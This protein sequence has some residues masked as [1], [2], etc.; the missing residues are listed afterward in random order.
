VSSKSGGRLGR[1]FFSRSAA[2]R[3]EQSG[4]TAMEFGLVITPFLMM[5]FAVINSAMYFFTV[6]SLDR[7]VEDT[8][9]QIR[10]GEFR[11]G[12]AN[13][14]PMKVGEFRDKIC[15]NAKNGGGSIDCSKLNILVKNNGTTWVGLAVDNCQTAGNLTQST[16][17]PTDALS[18]YV[19]SKE[20]VVMVTACYLWE[21]PQ[22]LP[23]LKLSNFGNSL[24][25]QSST[26]FKAEPY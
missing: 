1:G 2:F 11:V 17:A 20:A 12:G 10:T 7:G 3:N 24:L 18:T 4:T 26:T 22:Y 9:R 5:I 19:G 6:N 13:G 21:L 25:I 15:A 8:A 23:L 14:Q 16:G